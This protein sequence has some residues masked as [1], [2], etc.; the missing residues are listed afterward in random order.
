[1]ERLRGDPRHHEDRVKEPQ[2][3]NSQRMKPQ[4]LKIMERKE[5]ALRWRGGFT[6]LRRIKE[7]PSTLRNVKG[8]N[9]SHG[10]KIERKP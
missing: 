5:M 1:M 4:V 2:P 8:E 7:S 9:L 3:L 10:E 6:V